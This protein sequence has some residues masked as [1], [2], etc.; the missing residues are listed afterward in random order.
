M[1][2]QGKPAAKKAVTRKAG[3]VSK[4]E[5]APAKEATPKVKL[6][7]IEELAKLVDVDERRIRQIEQEG[8]IKSE[9]K[10]S[11][12]EKREYD[13]AKSIVALVR[14]YRK[15]ADSRRSGSSE[16]MES[17]KLLQIETKRKI[18]ELKLA[19]LEGELHRA[20][21]IERIMGN[22]L[23]RLRV[24]LLAIPMGLA[25]ILRDMDDIKDIAEKL[26]DRIRRAMNEVADFDLQKLIE[27]GDI[28]EEE[29]ED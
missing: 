16:D 22:L 29:A 4:K 13:F 2:T 25:P 23:T 24:N 15:K 26:D 17:A 28:A 12:K 1:K 20:D 14:Y 18:D 6:V 3:A 21:D 10:S 7:G 5:P 19:Q 9:P 11:N 8:V 27:E